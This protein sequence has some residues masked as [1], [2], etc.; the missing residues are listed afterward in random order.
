MVG[1]GSVGETYAAHS[2]M[3]SGGRRFTGRR[4]FLKV[5]ISWRTSLARLSRALIWKTYCQTSRIWLSSLDTY[6]NCQCSH[7]S[8]R[9]WGHHRLDSRTLHKKFL[10]EC[11]DELFD[12]E[13]E[14]G[15]EGHDDCGQPWRIPPQFSRVKYASPDW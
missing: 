7:R 14:D 2:E 12:G 10:V 6:F 5:I 8:T 15:I 13:L 1:R 9:G 3:I 11:S 4:K